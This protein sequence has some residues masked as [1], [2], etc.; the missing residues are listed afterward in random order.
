M[1][2][3]IPVPARRTLAVDRVAAWPLALGALLTA[4]IVVRLWA[5]WQRPVP[6]YFP[7]EYIYTSISRSLA[8]GHL[9][10]V[11]GHFIAFPA[12]L[13]PLL[14][15]PAWWFGSLETGYRITQGIGVVAMSTAAL[16]VWWG[17]RSLGV[18]R[19]PAFLAAVL[20]LAIPDLG[21][22]GWIVSEPFSY[23]LFIATVVAGSIALAR[24][25]RRS[26]GLFVAFAVLA[27][28]A[29]MQLVVLIP[30]Y[31]IAALL[32]R[33][34]RLQKFT[35]IGLG[36]VSAVVG[37]AMIG[38]YSH[39]SITSF[40]PAELGR[41]LY[42]LAF[43]AGWI[44]V[45]AGLLG[46]AGAWRSPRSDIERA[47]AAFAVTSSLAVVA[48]ATLYGNRTLVHE[49]YDFYVLPLLFL[50]FALH[51]SRGWPHSRIHAALA[52]IMLAIA[53]IVTL[54]EWDFSHSLVLVALRR[55]E[56]LAGSAGTAGLGVALAVGLMSIVSVALASRRLTTVIAVVAV[57]FCVA[58]SA[59]AVSFDN[60][61]TQVL[62]AS[63][64]PDGPDWISGHATVIRD[65]S[66]RSS[67]I[68][69]LFWNRGATNLALLPVADE[70][71]PFPTIK[72][73]LTDSGRFAHVTGRVVIDENGT[74]FLPVKPM[75]WNGSWLEAGSPQLV[76]VLVGR[77]ANTWLPPDGA[78]QLYRPGRLSFTI[79]AP[80]TQTLTIAGQ[81]L[82]LRAG[83]PTPVSICSVGTF[84]YH[85][86]QHGW[87]QQT[88][89]SAKATFPKF[90]AN[91]A[92]GAT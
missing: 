48:E 66:S 84:H 35:L 88:E 81:H 10:A 60:R 28:L 69:Q 16:F 31:L 18:G 6:D 83:V 73:R 13:E 11:R 20:S 1:E 62:A 34:L 59:L 64:L 70:P 74:A 86:S 8:A 4:N 42:V 41:N 67:T 12:L 72:T 55:L 2:L 47:F 65:G 54:S 68:L 40:S 90:Q 25:T 82:H 33:R 76:A 51:A 91:A 24:P 44:V 39:A 77:G 26:E 75:R 29:R 14:T 49:R 21:Y 19:G 92:C 43:A 89:V 79:T 56:Q 50:G 87:V 27:V 61:N 57:G 32:L 63:Y 52:A 23:P 78:G 36:A 30:A 58:T 45:P 80:V 9:P 7:D 37:A 22:S 46:I 15:A 17:A 85:F 5:A 71:D 3:G 53:S 38:F